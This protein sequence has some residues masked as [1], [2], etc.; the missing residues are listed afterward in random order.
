MATQFSTGVS[1]QSVSLGFDVIDHS[2]STVIYN[3]DGTLYSPDEENSDSKLTMIIAIVVPISVVFVAAVAWFCI[4][5][6]R[7][8]IYTHEMLGIQSSQI[9]ITEKKEEPSVNLAEKSIEKYEMEII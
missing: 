6:M 4:R 7:S 9:D 3:P 5:R 8:K 1:S 2:V